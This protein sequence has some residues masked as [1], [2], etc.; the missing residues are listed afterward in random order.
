MSAGPEFSVNQSI[1][2]HYDVITLGTHIPALISAALC[3]RQGLRVAV[4]GQ[5]QH[6][7]TYK[8]GS[9]DAPTSLPLL[10]APCSELG[11]AVQRELSLASLFSPS[12]PIGACTPSKRID[13]RGS[14]EQLQREIEREFPSLQETW[15]RWMK[16]S[17]QVHEQTMAALGSHA[18]SPISSVSSW[19]RDLRTRFDRPH[20]ERTSQPP[21]PPIEGD[22]LWLLATAFYRFSSAS[23]VS[24]RQKESDWEARGAALYQHLQGSLLDPIKFA[25]ELLLRI[26]RAG[27]TVQLGWSAKTIRRQV[28]G[29]ELPL[30]QERRVL[31]CEEVFAGCDLEGL[32]ELFEDVPEAL[33]ELN[34][35]PRT[36]L[37]F[38]LNAI[39]ER[40]CIP[41][42]VPRQLLAYDHPRQADMHLV[43]KELRDGRLLICAEQHFSL[44]RSNMS[45][46]IDRARDDLLDYLFELFPD[47]E[48]GILVVDSPHDGRS[49]TVYSEDKVASS[50]DLWN[51]G[52]QF[53]R[54]V[55]RDSSPTRKPR[56]MRLAPRVWALSDE[57]MGGCGFDGAAVVA[58]EV[59]RACEHHQPRRFRRRA[60]P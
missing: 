58:R 2:E 11:R 14:S 15:T 17:Q 9:V 29:L 49:P 60:F 26:E 54:R 5:G 56:A 40:N 32:V 53:A 6:A 35:R 38:V 18:R 1:E 27:G 45:E 33:D 39:C 36:H 44:G 37:R 24:N 4:L 46:R 3:A 13:L 23:Y 48:A 12:A 59:G 41:A 16:R 57:S 20:A 42:V 8:L 31:R 25:S 10:A 21:P 28:S 55:F 47:L 43:F 7:P 34:R 19:L 50:L 30:R 51:R 22:D 52:P